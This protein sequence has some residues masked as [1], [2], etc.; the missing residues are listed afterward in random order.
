MYVFIKI[1]PPV[2]PMWQG[3]TM[4]SSTGDTLTK[5]MMR[6]PTSWTQAPVMEA[7]MLAPAPAALPAVLT[8]GTYSTALMAIR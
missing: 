8:K 6:M 7:K 1:Y 4:I 2:V 3:A 5:F